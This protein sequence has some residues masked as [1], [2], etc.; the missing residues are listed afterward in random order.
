MKWNP[1]KSNWYSLSPDYAALHPGYVRLQRGE[2]CS[3]DEMESGITPQN[4]RLI[5]HPPQ[6]NRLEQFRVSHGDETTNT[7]NL[8]RD[9]PNHV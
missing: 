7:A 5:F 9:Q 8:Q 6:P 1:G 3:P 4:A 2:F